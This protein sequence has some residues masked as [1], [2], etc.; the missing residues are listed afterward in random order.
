MRRDARLG[1]SLVWR[2]S[3]ERVF[4]V[5]G[6]RLRSDLE[7]GDEVAVEHEAVAEIDNTTWKVALEAIGD[8][9]G[10]VVDR[11]SCKECP[12][13]RELRGRSSQPFAD[14]SSASIGLP[15]VSDNGV[16]CERSEGGLDIAP[17]VGVLILTDDS[18]ELAHLVLH[19]WSPRT[20]EA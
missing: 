1:G 7:R 3:S 18:W 16:R 13:V 4:C 12:R 20:V 6:A 11:F 19:G 8:E 14:L 2:S 9:P 10:A 15:I 5:P 17:I